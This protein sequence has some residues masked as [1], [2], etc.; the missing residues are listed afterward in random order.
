MGLPPRSDALDVDR[1][2]EVIAVGGFVAPAPLAGRLA[3]LA[4]RRRGA[5]AL[6]PSATRVGSKEGLTVLALTC[7][8]WTSHWP[9]S[10]QVNDRKIGAQKE[11]NREEKKRAEEERRKWT[12]GININWGEENETV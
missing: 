10:P 5:V 8:A 9:A 6:A 4:A 7:G 12:Q 1:A 11:E 2:G 3:G